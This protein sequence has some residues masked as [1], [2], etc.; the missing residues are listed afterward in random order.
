ME[1]KIISSVNRICTCCM[2]THNVKTVE[3]LEKATF[4]DRQ[5][6]Y[7]ATYYYCEV[8][9]EF[10]MDEDMITN[11]DMRMKDAY[12]EAE[13]LLTA[14]QISTVRSKYGVSQTDLCIMLGWGGK[15]ITRYEGHQVQDRAHD[16]ILKKIDEDPEWYLTLLVEAK[17]SLSTEVYKKYYEKATELYEKKQ[18][19][20][21]RKAI[22]ASYA[23]FRDKNLENGNAELSLD[24]AVAVIRYFAASGNVT[25]LYTVKLMKLLWYADALSFK[26]YGK[27]ITGLVYRAL[28][29]GAVPIEYNLIINLYGVP[30]QEQFIGDNIAYHF[31]LDSKP[32]VNYLTKNE[33]KV[34][35]II[36]KKLGKLSKD[37]IVEF[38]HNEQAYVNTRP[39]EVISFEYASELQI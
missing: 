7:I 14:A 25:N 36:I 18:D 5:V 2:E 39:N 23:R 38:M 9:D 17:N 11:N 35:D 21:K 24:K 32:E 10:Y 16:S 8:A 31:T 28:P 13:G 3:V 26:M 15:T 34:L 27:A 1:M 19:S 20:Y 30:V 22:E 29:M 6:E 33:K 4:K 37:E 12:R